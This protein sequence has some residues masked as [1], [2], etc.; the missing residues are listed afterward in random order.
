MAYGDP[1]EIGTH[2]DVF[3]LGAM[4]YEVLCDSPPHHGDSLMAVLS[5]RVKVSVV[6]DQLDA[7]EVAFNI[8][9]AGEIVGEIGLLDGRERTADAT[10]LED[11]ELLVLR[12]GSF[13]PFVERHPKLAMALIDLLC[14]RLRQT[15]DFVEDLRFLDVEKRLARRLLWLARRGSD[16]AS[17]RDGITVRIRHRDLA[18][19]A[20]VSRETTT[21]QISLWRNTGLIRTGTGYI[22]I[23]D[24]PRL[25]DIAG[26]TPP[27]Y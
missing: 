15:S 27:E 7:R 13:I 4:L 21:K 14:D 25:E 22:D 8:I 16:R 20:G 5:G 19:F 24:V 12:R 3:L 1:D 9:A 18:E 26:D 10:A 17:D 23:L 6:S 11:S 2:S